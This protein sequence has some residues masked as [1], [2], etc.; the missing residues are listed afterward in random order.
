MATTWFVEDFRQS[1]RVAIKQA[2]VWIILVNPDE[3]YFPEYNSNSINN[4]SSIGLAY[5]GIK[6]I[7]FIALT[8]PMIFTIAIVRVIITAIVVIVAIAGVIVV[9]VVTI[10]TIVIATAASTE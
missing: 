4:L 2:L 6:V 3:N 10:A 1:E 9:A 8:R 7:M 5:V